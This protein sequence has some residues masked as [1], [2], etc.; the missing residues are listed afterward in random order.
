MYVLGPMMLP[1]I[2]GAPVILRNV[3]PAS[4][5]VLTGVKGDGSLHE[6]KSDRTAS[7]GKQAELL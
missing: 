2:T 4:V 5:K 3:V 6:A 7:H 1:Y